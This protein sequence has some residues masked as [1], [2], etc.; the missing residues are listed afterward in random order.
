MIRGWN[1]SLGLLMNKENEIQPSIHGNSSKER[2]REK[3]GFR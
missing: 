1:G 3:G 2:E